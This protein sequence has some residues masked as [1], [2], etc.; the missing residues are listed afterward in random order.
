MA[1]QWVAAAWE[2]SGAREPYEASIEDGVERAAHC[3]RAQT[4]LVVVEHWRTERI[5]ASRWA[6][7]AVQLFPHHGVGLTLAMEGEGRAT[8]IVAMSEPDA[9][10]LARVIDP[11][12]ARWVRD[13]RALVGGGLGAA[14]AALGRSLAR[15][16][17][18]DRVSMAVRSA[19]AGPVARWV[20]AWGK[21]RGPGLWWI[22]LRLRSPSG[23]AL[24]QI[25]L[26]ACESEKDA[27]APRYR[28]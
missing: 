1:C 5:E 20:A 7:R 26:S 25:A 16:A 27:R 21:G 19:F 12:V 10:C 22:G 6:A 24:V 8:G 9:R 13:P 18:G 15:G 3:L 11:V 28:G 23:I 4:E 17:I 14:V 2:Q